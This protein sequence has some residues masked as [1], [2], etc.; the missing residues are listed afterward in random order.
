[1]PQEETQ[2]LRF[3]FEQID[4]DRSGY[5]STH[6]LNEAIKNSKIMGVS[7]KDAKS[8]VQNLD[9]DGNDMINYTEFLAATVKLDSKTLTQQRRDAIFKMF[10]IMD[11][12]KIERE[13]IGKAF[14]KFSKT[15]T[16]KE[17]DQIFKEFD[18]DND[19]VITKDEWE[20]IVDQIIAQS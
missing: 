3:A 15:I 4:K 2:D 6:E 19:G 16:E 8:I 7:S 9:E 5:I 14:N 13:H 18:K 17:I 1:M 11:S 20:I 12:G 10:D